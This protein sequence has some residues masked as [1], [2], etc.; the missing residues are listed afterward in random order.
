MIQEND[1]LDFIG[2]MSKATGV[3]VAVG[4]NAHIEDPD[5]FSTYMV[6]IDPSSLT[7]ED[8]SKLELNS[9]RQDLRMVEAWND[10]G[11]FLKISK[12]RSVYVSAF[13]P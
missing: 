6:L 4:V 3:N 11:R 13:S 10:W 12:L 8:E 1:A 7:D 9:E 5:P 2:D